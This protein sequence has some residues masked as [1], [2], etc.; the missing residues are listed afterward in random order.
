M[1]AQGQNHGRRLRAVIG[2]FVAGTNL[3]RKPPLPEQAEPSQRSGVIL[4][5]AARRCIPASAAAATL[6]ATF[7][8]RWSDAV[9][10]HVPC[11]G[12]ASLGSSTTAMRTRF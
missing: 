2:N 11:S 10:I 7:M 1:D 8:A 12:I 6:T 9:P 4:P 5:R 3:H